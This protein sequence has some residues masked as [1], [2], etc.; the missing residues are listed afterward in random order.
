MSD[1]HANTSASAGQDANSPNFGTACA[2]DFKA[3]L[4][5]LAALEAE[6]GTTIR[7]RAA[8]VD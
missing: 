8:R 5:V 2:P 1:G 7:E 4:D 6:F 3:L